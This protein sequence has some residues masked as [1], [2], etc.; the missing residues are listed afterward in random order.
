MT[1]GDPQAR[2]EGELVAQGFDLVAHED[3][4]TEPADEI[5]CRR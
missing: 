1:A 4:L 3:Q 2:C 5:T